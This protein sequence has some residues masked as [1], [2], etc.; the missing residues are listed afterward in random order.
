MQGYD[1]PFKIKGEIV[2]TNQSGVGIEYKDKFRT[3]TH[4][5]LLNILKP[6][7]FLELPFEIYLRD[8]VV[9]YCSLN[10]LFN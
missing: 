1:R 4:D 6:Y 7:K 2:R 8:N 10:D 5:L 9:G 3:P